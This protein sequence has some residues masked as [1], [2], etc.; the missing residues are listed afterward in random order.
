MELMRE[1]YRLG[2]FDSLDLLL[3]ATK[4]RLQRAQG[5][6]ARDDCRAFWYVIAQAFDKRFINMNGSVVD[7]DDCAFRRSRS[8]TSDADTFCT[9]ADAP[10][11]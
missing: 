11:T 7:A 2:E 4:Q 10:T 5:S 6:C 1:V 8:N 9:S 3:P